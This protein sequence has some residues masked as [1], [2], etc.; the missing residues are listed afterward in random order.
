ML[1]RPSFLGV[2]MSLRWRFN[3]EAVSIIGPIFLFYLNTYIIRQSQDSQLFVNSTS[4]D[5]VPQTTKLK[6]TVTTSTL[7]SRIIAHLCFFIHFKIIFYL[8]LL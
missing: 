3:L 1:V 4:P 8:D 5:M 2:L 6:S 7:R